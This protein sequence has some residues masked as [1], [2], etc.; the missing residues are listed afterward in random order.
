MFEAWRCVIVSAPSIHHSPRTASSPFPNSGAAL[1]MRQQRMYASPRR[2][3][4]VLWNGRR[5]VF[6]PGCGPTH[7]LDPVFLAEGR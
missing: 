5:A 7:A 4:C 1:P 2:F 3:K 6:A